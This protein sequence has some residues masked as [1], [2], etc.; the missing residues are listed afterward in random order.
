MENFINFLEIDDKKEEKSCN[1]SQ[2]VKKPAVCNEGLNHQK[3]DQG[4][5]WNISLCFSNSEFL[6]QEEF[7]S[8]ES[9]EEHNDVSFET[10][11]KNEVIN[12]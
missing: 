10:L 1:Q 12:A 2:H 5:Q 8:L 9:I 4:S 3:E 6:C 11:E 7:I